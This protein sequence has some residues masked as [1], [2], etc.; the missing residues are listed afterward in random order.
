MLKEI[1]PVV[2]IRFAS[3]YKSFD[4]LEDFKRFVDE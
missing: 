1:D 3:V 4:S 2:Y